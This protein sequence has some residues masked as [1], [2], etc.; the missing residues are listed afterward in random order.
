MCLQQTHPGKLIMRPSAEIGSMC[1]GLVQFLTPSSLP[2]SCTPPCPPS[3]PPPS[4]SHHFIHTDPARRVG[5]ACAQ[6]HHSRPPPPPVSGCGHHPPLQTRRG[7]DKAGGQHGSRRHGPAAGAVSDLCAAVAVSS[8]NQLWQP[9]TLCRSP[10]LHTGCTEATQ[11][12]AFVCNTPISFAVP[13]EV[14]S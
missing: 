4:I 9:C 11:S 2:P 14:V 5:G 8:H 1:N 10:V 12:N 6:D 13:K 7:H 3:R